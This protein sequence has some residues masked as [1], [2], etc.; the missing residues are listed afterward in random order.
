MRDL[1][2]I[3]ALPFKAIAYLSGLLEGAG[4]N[5]SSKEMKDTGRSHGKSLI[6]EFKE[7]E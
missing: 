6:D 4:L 3:L 2:N 5:T 7:V 1:L